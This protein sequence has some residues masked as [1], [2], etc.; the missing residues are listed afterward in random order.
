MRPDRRHPVR[1]A[2]SRPRFAAGGLDRMSSTRQGLA[3]WLGKPQ[4]T[5][6]FQV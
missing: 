1:L 6:I 3:I 5:A 4:D 2:L